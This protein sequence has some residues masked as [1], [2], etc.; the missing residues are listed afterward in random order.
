VFVEKNGERPRAVVYC[1]D[2][3]KHG[4]TRIDRFGH[5]APVSDRGDR[6]ARLLSCGG[7]VEGLNGGGFQF[8][9][10]VG[11]GEGLRDRGDGVHDPAGG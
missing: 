4:Y 11:V 1:A 6:P 7:E 10:R 9:R 8:V 3:D 5:D 2:P